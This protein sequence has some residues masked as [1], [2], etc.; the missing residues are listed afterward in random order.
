MLISNEMDV[1]YL[2][3]EGEDNE[4]LRYSLRTVDVNFPHAAIWLVGYKPSWVTNCEF[5]E[6]NKF[7]DYRRNIYD[8]I[9]LAA[10][11]PGVSEDFV[12]FND[13]FFVTAPVTELDAYYN[14]TIAQ[15]IKTLGPQ[16]KWYHESLSL[17]QKFLEGEGVA[18]PLTFEL[19]IP[20]PINKF[21]LDTALKRFEK[22]S[23]S[24]T[25]PQVRSLYANLSSV[26]R[27]YHSDVKTYSDK[28]S[29]MHQ[30]FHSSDDAIFSAHLLPE[31]GRLFPHPC[32]YERQ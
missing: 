31:L 21:Q 1:V 27:S 5:I 22:T 2:V 23:T 7:T 30:P 26:S 15:H 24:T 28:H 17:T 32:S 6:G 25:C 11:H 12:L 9:S 8:N 20:M 3:R 14:G 4:E 29:R 13:D 10:E 18:D 16:Q 19:H